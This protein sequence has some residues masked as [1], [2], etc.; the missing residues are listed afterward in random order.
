MDIDLLRSACCLITCGA[1]RGTGFLIA[2]ALVATCK[3]VVEGAS[4]GD[5]V[6][7]AF[8]G[9]PTVQAAVRALD[10]EDD[11]A[12]LEIVDDQAHEVR[13]IAPLPLGD[14][15][16]HSARWHG[17]GFPAAAGDR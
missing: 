13:S 6:T 9:G 4:L 11:A 7:L 3:H 15:C 17:Y 1:A 8:A 5:L 14:G 16:A 10:P 2:P 12:L